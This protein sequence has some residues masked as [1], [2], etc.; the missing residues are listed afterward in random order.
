MNEQRR[1][2][3]FIC[4][5]VILFVIAAFRGNID[6][7]YNGYIGLYNKAALLNTLRIEPTFLMIS[8]FIKHIFNNVLFLFITYA[9]LGVYLKFY[10]IK[11][12]TEFWFLAVL[13]YFSNFY[14]L[15][16]MTQIRVGI[17][18]AFILLSMKPLLERNLKLFLLLITISFLFH[19]SAILALPLYFL[20]GNKLNIT[21]FAL[22]IPAV[23]LL[24]F[25]HFRIT[26]LIDLIPI[27][28]V[29]IKFHQYKYLSGLHNAQK[30]NL[31]SYLQMSRCLLAYI[32]LW[33]WKLLQENNEYSVLLLKVYIIAI[34][35][36]VLLS[37]IPALGSRASELLMPVEIIL[38]PCLMYVFKPKLLGIL[39]IMLIGLMFLSLDL[40]YSKLLI[41]K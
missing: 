28:E 11:N 38:I 17:A 30:S 25:L 21:F 31:F 40:F 18:S 16:E 10:A 6:H 2:A 3:S 37:D 5:G 22:L 7:D 9:L 20:N 27:P 36:L 12:L 29:N 32:F 19:Y 35:I 1:N 4:L 33:K 26:Y 41:I 14:I 13:I 34:S 15:H 24:Y 39:V 23:Y 8:F